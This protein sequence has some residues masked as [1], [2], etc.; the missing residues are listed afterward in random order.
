[1][2]VNIISNLT[3]IKIS[4]TLLS[5][6]IISFHPM[7]TKSQ[8]NDTIQDID[9]TQCTAQISLLRVIPDIEKF[10]SKIRESTS[11]GH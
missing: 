9:V 4:Q 6:S 11:S 3:S 7:S 2:I 10:L 8:G 1:M 5:F